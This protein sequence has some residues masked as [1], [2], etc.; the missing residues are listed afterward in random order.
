MAEIDFEKLRTDA[1]RETL[2]SVPQ[3]AYGKMVAMSVESASQV[4]KKML[5]KYHNACKHPQDG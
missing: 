5:I 4:T 1:V 2:E 3:D